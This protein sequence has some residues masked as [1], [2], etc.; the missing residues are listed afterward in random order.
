MQTSA[1]AHILAHHY[2]CTSLAPFVHAPNLSTAFRAM[3]KQDM[4]ALDPSTASI[5]IR[6]SWVLRAPLRH[7]PSSRRSS[8]IIPDSE[9][10]DEE[11]EEGVDMMSATQQAAVAIY[12]SPGRVEAGG[13]PCAGYQLQLADWDEVVYKARFDSP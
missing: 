1:D 12:E 3:N 9:D 6:S 2:L 7:I 4:H 11:E 13:P 5:I 10:E 8:D